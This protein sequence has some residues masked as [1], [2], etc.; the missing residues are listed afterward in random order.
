[1]LIRN[2]F[3]AG[4]HFARH[5]PGRPLEQRKKISAIFSTQLST[6]AVEDIKLK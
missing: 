5:L 6:G 1:L 4:P 2:D 3:T